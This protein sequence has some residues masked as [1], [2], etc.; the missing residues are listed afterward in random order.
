MQ[1]LLNGLQNFSG[2]TCYYFGIMLK[3]ITIKRNISRFLLERED[4][5]TA[6]TNVNKQVGQFLNFIVCT[7]R[8]ESEL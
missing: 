1:N 2:I 4:K 6:K 3:I 8:P 5:C 7:D